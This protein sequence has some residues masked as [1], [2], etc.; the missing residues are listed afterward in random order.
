VVFCSSKTAAEIKWLL[1][2]LQLRIPFIA[3]NGG[4]IFLPFE[5]CEGVIH[6]L[7]AENSWGMIAL[8]TGYATLVDALAE[9]KRLT[10]VSVRGFS[11][12][13]AEQVAAESGLTLE[14]ARLARQR[15][16]DE[17][18]L[19]SPRDDT[20]LALVEK[21]AAGAGLRITRGGRFLHLM[22][23]NDKGL[24][25]R[26]LNQ[27]LRT[28]HGAIRTIGIGDSLNDVGMLSA[29]DLPILVARPDG[30]HEEEVVRRV[31]HTVKAQGIGPAAWSLTVSRIIPGRALS[32][33]GRRKEHDR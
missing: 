15:E 7:P 12:M 14:Q 23:P 25:V 33:R 30:R 32:A 6:P 27:L 28:R 31:P 29:V 21:T 11:D 5:W 3:E 26:R 8:G 1:A 20:T 2:E 4:A 9:L 13:T 19:L 10:G 24:A 17:P 16:F 22:G 18:F